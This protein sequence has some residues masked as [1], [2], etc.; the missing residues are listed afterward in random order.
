MNEKALAKFFYEQCAG[1]YSGHMSHIANNPVL[2]GLIS[3]ST[4]TKDQCYAATQAAFAKLLREMADQLD[5]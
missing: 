1:T 2:F 4:G 3:A 5:S